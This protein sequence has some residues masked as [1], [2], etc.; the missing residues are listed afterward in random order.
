MGLQYDVHMKNLPFIGLGI[1]LLTLGIWGSSC[2]PEQSTVVA[3]MSLPN[4]TVEVNELISFENCSEFAET[5]EWYFG[6]EQVSTEFQP[7]HSYSQG[8]VYT[9]I[10]Q[11][12]KADGA[13]DQCYLD[14]VV[15]Q[16]TSSDE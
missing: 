4:D 7:Q 10:L 11:A 6:D 2:T 5:Y 13:I 8:G 12:E 16:P 9:I 15:L 1:A 3:C 14:L